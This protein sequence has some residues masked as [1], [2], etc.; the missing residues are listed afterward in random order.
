M[1]TK[2]QVDQTSVGLAVFDLKSWNTAD[3][4][5]INADQWRPIRMILP[6]PSFTLSPTL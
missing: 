2:C 1:L 6:H 3:Y 5:H 4:F